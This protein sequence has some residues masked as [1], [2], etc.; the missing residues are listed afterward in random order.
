MIEHLRK[1]TGLIIFVIAL[2]FVGLAFFGDRASVG[3][4][5]PD[6]P[7][8]LTVDGTGYTKANIRKLA[9]APMALAQPSSQQDFMRVM[10]L[11]LWEFAH[12]VAGGSGDPDLA[13]RRFLI[14]RLN[15]REAATEFGIYPSDAEVEVR[16]KKAFTTGPD[17]G[18]DKA[19]YEEE[20][21][22]LERFGMKEKD[23][24]DLV[25]DILATEKLKELLGGGLSGSLQQEE[26]SYA[27]S[28][29]QVSIQVART[30][31]ASFQEQ[32]KPTDED[33]KAAWE[34]TKDQYTVERKIKVSYL[35][36]K[37][38]YPEKKTEPAKLPTAVT[39]ED[40]KA[41]EKA[42][43]ER[44][45]KEDAAYAETKRAV[46]NEIYNKVTII[47]DEIQKS[48]GKDFEKAVAEQ[49]LQLVTT[50]F[51]Q[52]SAMPPELSITTA[53]SSPKPVGDLLLH[54][55]DRKDDSLVNFTEALQLKDSAYLIARLDAEEKER[56][57]TF[58]EAKDQVRA[59][60]IEKKSNE[61]LRKDA[62]EKAAKIREGLK[63]GKSFADLAKEVGLE[64]KAHGP[65]KSTDKLEGE[66]DVS[67]LFQT[68][69]TVDPGTLADPVMKPDS[70]IFI[71]VE[72]RE[73]VKDPSRESTVNQN[74]E[75]MATQMQASAFQSWLDEKMNATRV[76]DPFAKVKK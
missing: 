13:Q 60:Y 46:D 64:P 67:T 58:E 76:E 56:T 55:V 41:E 26:E 65:F 50:D 53:D 63:S 10:Q 36:A 54:L 21:K 32:V 44:K 57:K 37:P 47:L 61:L 12:E 27:T 42:E 25:R 6:N 66:A 48:G 68:A 2:L 51:F 71:F 31:L 8:L 4:S 3:H 45:A 75:R 9:L 22:S 52:R 29:Q 24:I 73:L 18:F 74:V 23:F 40:K 7:V 16:V 49:G 17:G 14:N 19:G 72:K 5:S 62:D 1:Y 33:L 15:I 30:S 28:H 70:A 34:T 11:G 20:V 35:L 69:S 38:Q 39:E 59:D 43:Q